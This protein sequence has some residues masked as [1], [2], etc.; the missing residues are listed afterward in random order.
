[1]NNDNKVETAIAGLNCWA[2]YATALL[3]IHSSLVLIHDFV[4][5]SLFLM[6]VQDVFYFKPFF[7]HISHKF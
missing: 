2:R 6:L 3:R 4:F 1:M 7:Y 5:R